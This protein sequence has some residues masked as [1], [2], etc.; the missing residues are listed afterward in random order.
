MSNQISTLR[1]EQKFKKTPAGEIPVDW[2]VV[3][4]G[5]KISLEYGEGLI[6]SKRKYGKYPVYGSNGIIGYHDNFLIKGP[7]IVVGRKGTIGAV[8]WS[9]IDFWPID[10]TYYIKLFDND[11]NLRWLYYKL[12]SLDL[13]KLNMAT[14]TP[15]LNR[16]IACSQII[17]L[18][19]PA[20]QKKIAD[21]LSAVDDAIDKTDA[22]IEKTKELKK[23]LAQQLLYLGIQRHNKFKNSIGGKIPVGWQYLSLSEITKDIYRYPTYYN[24]KYLANGVPEV[25]GEL[26]RTNGKLES[27]KAQYRSISEETAARFPRTRLNRG[28]LVLSVRGTIGKVAIVPEFLEGANMTANLIRISPNQEIV[29]PKWLL[30]VFISDNFRHAL[31]AASSSTAIKTITAP[32]LKKIGIA[33]PSL[34]E[35]KEIVKLLSGVDLSISHEEAHKH[36]LEQI[37]TALMQV[38][39]TGKVRV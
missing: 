25:R 20:E 11:L 1:M 16:D 24:I 19:P 28:D 34:S 31:D 39:L 21:I 27:D 8:S 7:G 30:Q 36:Q 35:Q 12:K 17:P 14:G 37:K 38:L 6:E 9:N 32:D 3:K 10:T 26:I 18:P 29:E 22:V 33:I 15:G 23:G 2:E 5:D 4:L 13:S